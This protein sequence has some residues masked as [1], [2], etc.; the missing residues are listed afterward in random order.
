MSPFNNFMFWGAVAGAMAFRVLSSPV[1]PLR[2]VAIGAFGGLFSAVI[3]TNAIVTHFNLDPEVYSPVVA[4]VLTLTGE[5]L[6]RW[7]MVIAKEPMKGIDL[8]K[9][10]RGK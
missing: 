8:L 6:L 5:S 3:F 9:A 2:V 10:W 1:K 4:A 7:L